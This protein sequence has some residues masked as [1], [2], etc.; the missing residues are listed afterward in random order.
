VPTTSRGTKGRLDKQDGGHGLPL[1]SGYKT[2]LVDALQHRLGQLPQ[3]FTTKNKTHVEAHA[4]AWLHLNPHIRQATLY[5]NRR[6]CPDENG[7]RE[8]LP[9][10]LPPGTRLT[11]YAP[12]GRWYIYHGQPRTNQEGP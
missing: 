10:M 5:V 7:C 11:I 4:A 8:R 6:P 3:G 12:D 9:A 1:D 2:G